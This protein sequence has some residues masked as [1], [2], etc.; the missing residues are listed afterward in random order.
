MR[1]VVF[2]P[3]DV[4]AFSVQLCSHPTSTKWALPSTVLQTSA[5]L[6]WLATV[7]TPHDDIMRICLV[8]DAPDTFQ[9][10]SRVGYCDA[11]E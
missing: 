11:Y 10:N 4:D 6:I 7:S 3:V 5:P 2:D 1:R 8:M 9:L